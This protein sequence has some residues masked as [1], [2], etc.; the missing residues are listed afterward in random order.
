MDHDH[1]LLY[2]EVVGRSNSRESGPIADFLA[3]KKAEQEPKTYLGYHTSLRRF[4]QFLDDEATVGDLNERAGRDF[5][6]E[7]RSHSL[8]KNTLATYFRDLKAFTRWLHETGWTE[9]DRFDDLKRPEFV[10]PKFDTLTS[11]QKQAILASCNPRT[12]LGARNLA[13]LC[14]FMDT[15]MRREELANVKEKRTHLKEG[16]VEVYGDK[17]DEWRI[18]PLSRE[19]VGVIEKYLRIR[20]RYFEKPCRHRA[21]PDD[22]NHRRKSVRTLQTDTLFC[23]W[24]GDSLTGNAVRLMIDRLREEL[25]RRGLPMK[26][27]AHL[28]RHNFLTEKA[29]DGENPSLV[30]RWAGHKKYEMTDYYFG[31]AED[32][33]AAI[34]PR[35]STL[36]GL[37]LPGQRQTPRKHVRAAADRSIPRPSAD[38]KGVSAFE[39]EAKATERPLLG[40]S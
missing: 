31:I 16:Y 21:R 30:K 4:Q 18:I 7:L 20:D 23:S 34:Q 19:V 32:K 8:S 25:A 38:A 6:A 10:R 37:R 26:L 36:A 5:L 39:H 40:I 15:G 2:K 17:T 29:L 28:F 13:V 24:R 9:R 22:V 1:E 3:K 12:F 35:Q 14:L 27:H 33:L 11:D